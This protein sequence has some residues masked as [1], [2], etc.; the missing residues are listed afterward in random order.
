MKQYVSRKARRQ[1]D[2]ACIRERS[3]V[4]VRIGS[5]ANTARAEAMPAIKSNT[6]ERKGVWRQGCPLNV[7]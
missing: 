4:E 6:Y 7:K 1:I 5:E 3:T 2:H